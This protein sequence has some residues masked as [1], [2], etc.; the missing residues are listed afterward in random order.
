MK[1]S[2]AIYEHELKWC[3]ESEEKF[4]ILSGTKICIFYFL[5]EWTNYK[6]TFNTITISIIYK[7]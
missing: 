4:K 7:P 2:L 1:D 3:R 6:R 5:T